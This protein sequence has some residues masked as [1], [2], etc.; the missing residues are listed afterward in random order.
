[1]LFTKTRIEGVFIID[2]IQLEDSRGFF[3]RSW[4]QNEFTEHGLNPR[5]VQCNISYNKLRGTIRGIHYQAYP[6]EE[7]KLVRCTMGAIYDVALDLRKKSPTFKT[8]IALELTAENHRALYIPEGCA[9]G[10]QSLTN[11]AEVLYQMSEFYFPEA[12]TGVRWNDLAFNIEWPLDVTTISEKDN[13][14]PD[15]GIE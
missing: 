11:N 14:Y 5:L 12:S 6:H 15:W 9:H 2:L 13:A 8:W 1:M 7:A 3:G 4:C 10:F